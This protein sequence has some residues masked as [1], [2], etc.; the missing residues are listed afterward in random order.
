MNAFTL[1]AQWA[2]RLFRWLTPIRRPMQEMADQRWAKQSKLDSLQGAIDTRD[3]QELGDDDREAVANF[4]AQKM[5]WSTPQSAAKGD[6]DTWV[7]DD[8]TIN[9][10][11]SSL[12]E[13]L[14]IALLG[15]LAF[16]WLTANKP[17]KPQPATG[18]VTVDADDSQYEIL[19]YDKDGKPITVPHISLRD[20]A[21]APQPKENP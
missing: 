10:G 7:C 11:R 18:A 17:A 2:A 9:T 21:Q 8:M 3:W 12:P 1:V 15:C 13:V 19:F 6:R 16:W 20:K 14:I 5:N 4:R